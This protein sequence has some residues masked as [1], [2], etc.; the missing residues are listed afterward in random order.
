MVAIDDDGSGPD[1]YIDTV[2]IE[3]TVAN[4]SSTSLIISRIT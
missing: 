3:L 2:L 1:Q 4:D